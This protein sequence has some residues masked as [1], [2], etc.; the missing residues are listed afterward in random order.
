[1][2]VLLSF[3]QV[4]R[5]F[6]SNM[7]VPHTLLVQTMMVIIV[8]GRMIG[9][10]GAV[11]R[12]QLSQMMVSFYGMACDMLEFFSQN[13]ELLFQLSSRGET[14]FNLYIVLMSVWS[15][16][17]CQFGLNVKVVFSRKRKT[18]DPRREE[19]RGS[20]TRMVRIQREYK[21]NRQSIANR[22]CR[23]GEMVSILTSMLLQDGIYLAARM[24]VMLKYFNQI[25]VFSNLLFYTCKNTI[26][27]LIL[28]YRLLAGLEEALVPESVRRSLRSMRQRR[29]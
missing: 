22:C 28:S 17:L 4:Q 12:G 2:H 8:V 13:S 3:L 5:L 10:K 7:L 6:K 29:V 9:P 19:D 20:G 1:M 11:T 25:N 21:R 24:Y 14:F 18:T 23:N 26:L 27:I 15:L 16:S